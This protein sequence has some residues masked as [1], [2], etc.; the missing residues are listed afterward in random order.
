VFQ[1]IRKQRN[2]L[3][4]AEK[5]KRC[6]CLGPNVFKQC[7]FPALRIN[8]KAVEEPSQ[9]KDPDQSPNANE[10]VQ[11]MLSNKFSGKRTLRLMKIR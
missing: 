4:E 2:N 11:S 3:T 5:I 7:K 10:S 8:T 9:P 1:T 6:S